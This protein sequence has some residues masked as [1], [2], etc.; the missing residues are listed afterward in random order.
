MGT[1]IKPEIQNRIKIS[2]K[3]KKGLAS[4]FPL[5]LK[6]SYT[7]ETSYHLQLL[8]LVGSF[9]NTSKVSPVIWCFSSLNNTEFYVFV[10]FRFWFVCLFVYRIVNSFNRKWKISSE[11]NKENTATSKNCARSWICTQDL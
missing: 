3:K 11:G 2:G 1:R 8:V 7:A 4:L 10:S 5:P 6:D 9:L